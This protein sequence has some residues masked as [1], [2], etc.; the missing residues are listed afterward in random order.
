MRK[1]SNQ[2]SFKYFQIFGAILIFLSVGFPATARTAELITIR[3]KVVEETTNRPVPSAIVAVFASGSDQAVF[4]TITDENGQFKIPA[5]TSGTYRLRIG[6]IGYA[7]VNISDIVLIEKTPDKDLGTIKLSS[8]QTTIGE[9]SIVATK[10]TLEFG[11]DGVTYNVDNSVLSEGSTA[12]DIL[13]NVPLVQVDVDGNATIAGKRSTRVFIDGKPSDYMTSNITDL[14]NVLP[15]DAIDKIEVL[16]NPPAKYSGDGEGIINIVMKK[17]F[18]VGFNGNIG[19]TAGTR[20]NINSNAN[21]SYRSKTWSVNGSAAYR[22]NIGKGMGSSF[23][24]NFFPDTTF[25]YDQHY[26]NRNLGTGENFRA[27]FDW[28]ITPRQNLRISTNFNF[29]DHNNRSGSDFHYLNT[30]KVETR[31]RDQLNTTLGDNN[32]FAV[33]VDYKLN[34]DTSGGKITFGATVNG[35]RSNDDRNY[36]RTYVPTSIQQ[37]LQNNISDIENRG[38]NFNVDFDKPVFGKRDLLEFGLQYN[39][40]N[41]DNDLK[42][43]NYNYSANSFVANSGLTNQFLYKENIYAG[44]ASYTLKKNG[45]SVRTG[46]RTEVTDVHFD[47][48]TGNVYHVKP[49]SSIFPN[50]SINRFFLKRYNVGASFSVRV[51][52]PRESFLNPQVNNSD[53]LN[54]SFG[55][56]GLLPAYTRQMDISFGAFGNQWSFTPRFSYSA[57]K[58]VI[59]RYRRVYSTGVAE[60]TFENV[61]SNSSLALILIGNYRPSKKISTHAN[62]TVTHSNYT[63]DF[64]SSLNRNGF[65]LRSSAGMSIQFPEKIA[66]ESNIN[67]ANNINAQGRVKGSVTTSFA[68]RKIFFKNKLNVRISAANPFGN[69]TNTTYNSGENFYLDSQSINYSSNVNFSLNYRFTKIQKKVTVPPPKKP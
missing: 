65:S 40:R 27:G 29:S 6:Y 47:L 13:K 36:L 11:A 68:A 58:G 43:F 3:G 49:Y 30:S 52:R 25:Y 51:N 20:G 66:F 9:V 63:S 16:T 53:P 21:A 59:E 37:S 46:L 32:T 45:W 1:V 34:I 56:P 69:T 26:N 39:Y 22:E 8:D 54:I 60:N 12:T 64:N 31:K 24:T 10:P 14:L 28:D 42:V 62:F 2:I 4:T 17:G 19:I 50:I 33:N 7:T 23:R 35:N 44:Y 38:V 15:S 5:L 48:S 41:N 61:G 18:K 67:Y 57:S 55:N